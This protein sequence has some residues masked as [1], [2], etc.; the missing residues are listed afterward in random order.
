M[1]LGAS[2]MI[3]G[4]AALAWLALPTGTLAKE[5]VHTDTGVTADLLVDD[6]ARPLAGLDETEIAQFLEAFGRSREVAEIVR[7]VDKE[8][9]TVG[10]AVP[11]WQGSGI[12][13]IAELAAR[14]GGLA[15]NLLRDQTGNVPGVTDFSGTAQP[16]LPGFATLAMRP[17]Q[18]GAN[19]RNFASFAPGIWVALD[20]RRTARGNAACYR[21][22]A[23]VT[24]YSRTPFAE[25]DGIT[26]FGM[27]AL[28]AGLD[29]MGEGEICMVYERNGD[30]Y[31]IRGYRPDGRRL[32]ELDDTAIAYRIMPAADLSAFIRDT[33][34]V[35]YDE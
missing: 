29:R 5:S 35:G 9:L 13:I 3:A 4:A 24:I 30:G 18:P 2:T 26:T 25:W 14:E 22:R 1:R 7:Q 17:A 6:A 34:P 20:N 27:A 21:G 23:G 11:G 10:K 12:D 15:G 8:L 32:G 33:V 31:A 16:D 19:E 28:I